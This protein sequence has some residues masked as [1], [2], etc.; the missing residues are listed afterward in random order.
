MLEFK[1]D[2]GKLVILSADPARLMEHPE[3]Q[4]LL[5]SVKEYMASK[6]FEPQ[7]TLSV[8]QLENLLTKPSDKRR[9]KEKI[10]RIWKSSG[11]VAH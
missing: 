6:D 10:N 5:Q 7:I 2:K 4:W 3:W 11:A 8:K 1:V 9:N